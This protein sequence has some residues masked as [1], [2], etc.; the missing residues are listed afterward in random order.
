MPFR[1]TSK[2]T[3]LTIYILLEHQST[4]DRMMG[5][6]LLSYMCQIWHAQLEQLANAGV[7]SSQQRLR[8]I[9][10]IVFYTGDREWK[11]P[12][13]LDAVMDVPEKMTPYVPSFKTHFLGIKHIAPDELTQTDHPFVWLMTVLQKGI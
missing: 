8:P 4:A 13:S 1:D 5:Y 10:P 3:D 7:K 9:V 11:T 6:R 12:V 2:G